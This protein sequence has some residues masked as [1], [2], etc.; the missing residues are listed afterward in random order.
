MMEMREF[1]RQRGV[2]RR[3]LTDLHRIHQLAC[4]IFGKFND[5]CIEWWLT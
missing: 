2:I 5:T 1:V 3:S 4:L